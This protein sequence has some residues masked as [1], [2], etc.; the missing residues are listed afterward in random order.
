MSYFL[1]D[2]MKTMKVNQ[3]Y[4]KK[5]NTLIAI[6]ELEANSMK[7]ILKLKPK[8]KSKN[9]NLHLL[10]VT[11]FGMQLSRINQNNWNLLAHLTQQKLLKKLMK[12]ILLQ[13]IIKMKVKKHQRTKIQPC[14][15]LLNYQL[16]KRKMFSL[17]HFL[18]VKMKFHQLNKAAT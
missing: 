10:Q 8:Q 9:Y 7:L 6:M 2:F 1:I 4:Q 3:N 5:M 12:V 13:K 18:I 11:I 15:N 16:I 17:L 14:K